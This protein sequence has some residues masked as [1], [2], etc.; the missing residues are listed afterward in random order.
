MEE[1]MSIGRGSRGSRTPT[2][3]ELCITVNGRVAS[4]M[5]K[6]HRLGQMV[7]AMLENG[8]TTKLMVMGSLLMWKATPTRASG[9]MTK[10]MATVNT[11][12]STEPSTKVI[13]KT[14]CNMG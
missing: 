9:Q 14:T 3:R 7:Q 1:T 11:C 5:V 13:G 4:E 10:P 8:E 12:I 6:G 2:R